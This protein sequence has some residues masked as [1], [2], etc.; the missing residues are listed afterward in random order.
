MD[1]LDIWA[2]FSGGGRGAMKLFLVIHLHMTVAF[3]MAGRAGV[4]AQGR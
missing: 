2:V 4:R 3:V 1:I